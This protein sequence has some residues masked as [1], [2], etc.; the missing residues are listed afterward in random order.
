MFSFCSFYVLFFF[1]IVHVISRYI[2]TNNKLFWIEIWRSNLGKRKKPCL[3]K[4]YWR[5][6]GER[7]YDDAAHRA[8]GTSTQA[9][10]TLSK[11]HISSRLLFLVWMSHYLER[12]IIDCSSQSIVEYMLILIFF[13]KN[14]LSF[15][16]EIILSYKHCV[17]KS[18]SNK[19]M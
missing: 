12:I 14:N 10:G 6:K 8:S 2:Y 15:S 7:N 11:E 3:G 4:S 17:I 13:L 18:K 5:T 1:W 9:K 19:Y 16:N